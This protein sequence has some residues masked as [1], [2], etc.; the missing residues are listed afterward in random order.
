MP[1]APPVS[2][3][4]EPEVETSAIETTVVGDTTVLSVAKLPDPPE[5]PRFVQRRIHYRQDTDMFARINVPWEMTVQLVD[6]SIAGA[7]FDRQL[8]CT[9]GIP[10]QF[11][12]EV[13][14][15]GDVPILGTVVWMHDGNCGVRFDMILGQ[16]GKALEAELLEQERKHLKTRAHPAK[17]PGSAVEQPDQTTES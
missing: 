6:I 12:I 17:S 13:P 5:K 9:P 1:T 4:D 2:A 14:S 7:R 16:K 10:I 15:M 11:V 3:P 8:P